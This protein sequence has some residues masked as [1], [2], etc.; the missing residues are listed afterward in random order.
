MKRYW[1]YFLYVFWHKVFVFQ[2]GRRIGVPLLSL[3]IH[4]WD[5]FLPDMFIAYAHTFY[6]ADGSKRT[7]GFIHEAFDYTWNRHQKWNKHHWQWWV[8]TYDSKRVG[9]DIKTIALQ[10]GARHW[11]EMV[12]D[13]RGVG[14]VFGTNTAV[15]YAENKEN[16]QLHPITQMQVEIML[17]KLDIEDTERKTDPKYKFPS[18][19]IVLT[20]MKR[21]NKDED[22]G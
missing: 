10:M 7:D 11:R 12:A 9:S 3:L 4:D 17:M 1:V 6:N 20:F 14:R 2:E 22:L 13:W 19:P 18:N 15:W 8:M 16:M 5:K 21:K